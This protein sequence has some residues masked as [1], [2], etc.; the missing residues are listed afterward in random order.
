MTRFSIAAAACLLSWFL[1]AHADTRA[2]TPAA[3]S[4]TSRFSLELQGDAPYYAITLPAPV[5]AASRRGDLGDVRIYNG[6]GEPVPY[7]LDAPPARADARPPA[8]RSVHWFALP[9]A[10]SGTAGNS[11]AAAG[12]NVTIAADGS[13]RAAVNTPPP[14]RRA[15]DLVDLNPVRGETRALLIH[16]RND[17]YQGRVSIAASDDLRNWTQAADVSL[18]KV[19]DGAST[20]QQERVD[21]DGLHARYL[22][23]AWPDGAPE[24]AAIEAESTST[25][26]AA[27][28]P[29]AAAAGQDRTWISGIAAKAGAGVGEYLFDTG[30]RYPVDRL[31]IGLPQANTV[32]H[33]TFYSRA[34][35]QSA[36]REVAD[37]NVFRLQKGNKDGN[38]THAPPEEQ[39]NPP[40]DIAPDSDR[41]WRI[42]VDT[43]NG[44][45][46]SGVP[47]VD[48]G[49]R[50]ATLTFVARG[51]APFTLV[52]G[53]AQLDTAAI[54]R[55][56][57]FVGGPAQI[58]VA[59]LGG[60]LPAASKAEPPPQDRDAT[61]RYVLWAALLAAVAALGFMAWRL[62]RSPPA[63]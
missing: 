28:T 48:I 32:A 58:A 23:L 16:L 6:A 27:G 25:D 21:L 44:G 13:L 24:I 37:A 5:F 8:V 52:A 40:L 12:L 14:A 22:K 61:R 1:P 49:W 46:G 41:E 2:D 53:N 10:D 47:A 20:I 63:A 29:P 11:N 3:P 9:A 33:A 54:G 55:A 30:G 17:N 15:G 42:A 18:L 43:R 4:F 51:A 57:L 59:R 45:L 35:A 60:A 39:R 19:S 31:Q 62:L 50:A 56:D 38:A 34:D 7:S 36:W 26:T